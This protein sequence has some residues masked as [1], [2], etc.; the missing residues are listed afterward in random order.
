MQMQALTNMA[1]S[2]QPSGALSPEELEEHLR[3]CVQAF[4]EAEDMTTQARQDAELR[5]DYY[6]GKQY[7]PAEVAAMRKRGQAPVYDNHIR[8]KVES[9]CNLELRTRTDPK[10][11][12]RNPDDERQADAATDSLRFIA[13]E[14]RWPAVRSE[15]F[16]DILIEGTGAVEVCVETKRNGDIKI[17]T[18][19]IPWDRYF[20]D[21]HS[22]NLDF[23][24][25]TY[26]GIV[27][28][29]DASAVKRQYPDRADAV[30][31]TLTASGETYDDRPKYT[32]TDSK[33]KRVR[34]VQIQYE[35]GGEWHVA[36]FT[37]GGFLVDPV[38]S[39]YRNKDGHSVG[40]II[41][42]SGYVDRENNR[43]GHVK[44]LIPLQDEINKR[45]S[46]ALHLMSQRQTFSNK[47][48]VPDVKKAKMELAKPDGH[49]ELGEAAEFGKDFGVLPTGDMVQGQVLMLDQA[50][51]SMNATGANAAVQGKDERTQSGVALQTRI[52][53]GAAELGPQVEGLREM[54]HRVYEAMWMCVRQ[55]WTG[56]KWVRVTDD[57]RNLRWVG[58]NRPVTML[59]KLKQQVAQMPRDQQGPALE[60]LKQ[61]EQDPRMQEVVDV[62]NNV[63]GLDVDII[64]D[65]GPDIAVLQSEQFQSLVELAGTPQ[66]QQVIPFTAIIK[67]S[68]LRNKDALL[69]EIEKRQ[70][71]MQQQQAQAAQEA[72][73]LGKAKAV[74]D[75]RNKDADTA[76]KQADAQAT[77]VQT[78]ITGLQ[79]LMPQ[80]Q[81]MLQ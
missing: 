66:G 42:R 73:Q 24:D 36:T 41:A 44:D 47:R 22:R 49:V 58:L 78:Q 77:E 43:Y 62:E 28:W 17:V 68:S 35:Y 2:E 20:Y 69:D 59:E 3:F 9:I 52:Q 14:N 34:V 53:S 18:K 12:P 80:P 7:T 81:P 29:D 25:K 75:I 50:L 61:F 79:A 40:S 54:T 13:D 57:D 64:V 16:A 5:R 32:W 11:F 33:R 48:A 39:P 1:E 76:K 27:I 4:E 21:P 74:A 30:D 63:S 38:V 65:E 55:F 46:K 51:T 60:Q 56:E 45:R 70:E 31:T 71:Q 67:A 19:R 72:A 23:S 37:K 26:D 6:D 10:A 15:V 8:R